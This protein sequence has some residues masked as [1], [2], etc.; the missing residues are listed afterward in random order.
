MCEIEGQYQ[1]DCESAHDRVWDHVIW[2][3]GAKAEESFTHELKDKAYVS[4]I[5]TL[6]FELSNQVANVSVTV[7]VAILRIS[8]MSQDFP[9]KDVIIAAVCL[10]SQY[11]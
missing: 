11:L 7:Q 10:S 1:L 2:K 6:M 8:K 5:R 3:P 4:A 9:F